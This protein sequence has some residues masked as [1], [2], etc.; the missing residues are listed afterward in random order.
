MSEKEVNFYGELPSGRSS[1]FEQVSG[2]I[3]EVLNSL[4]LLK[5]TARKLIKWTDNGTD[6][7]AVYS[8]RK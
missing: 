8:K 6:A 2:S 7:T 1:N 3:Q 4:S 5:I